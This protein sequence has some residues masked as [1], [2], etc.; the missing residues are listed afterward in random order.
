MALQ[1]FSLPE[2][3]A[4]AKIH[5]FYCSDVKY[6]PDADEVQAACEQAVKGATEVDLRTQ[7]LLHKGT[8]YQRVERL[9]HDMST[10]N[11]YRKSSYVT[12]TG[13]GSGGAP[14]IFALEGHENRRQRMQMGDLIRI[15]SIASPT[16]WVLSLHMSG[17]LYRSLD[18]ITE[19]I[20]NSRATVLSVGNNMPLDEVV[21]VLGHSHANVITGDS[22]Q[23]VQLVR[24]I[25]TLP[26]QAQQRLRLD[27]I[28]YTSEPLTGTQRAFIYTT[29]GDVKICSFMGSAEVGPWA[30]SHPD[31]G[32]EGGLADSSTRDFVF[33]T[34]S[35]IIEILPLTASEATDSPSGPDP[36]PLG[37]RGIIVQTSLQRLRNPLVRYITGDIGSLHQLT[38]SARALIPETDRQY[39]RVLRMHGRDRRFGFKWYGTYF[40]FENL[41]ALMLAE[42]CGI[43]QWQVILDQLKS[44]PQPTL[45]VRLLRASPQADILSDEALI[46][47]LWTFFLVLPENKDLFRVEFV[48]DLSGF[49]RS[50]TGSKVIQFLDK[51]H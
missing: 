43:L 25:S 11:V 18:L 1:R 36:L 47:R 2:V 14:M 26:S 10:K 6:P 51:L 31:L 19:I 5:P 20:E 37:E 4:V 48:K 23:I 30:V 50:A 8:I 41:K 9:T 21:D 7:P 13:G 16:D 49:E 35:M 27:K 42:E 17:G 24:Y 28:I 22:S 29:L 33:D 46:R 45:E 32:G 39:L 15:C 44:S 12:V 3:L 34:R 40:E 38:P